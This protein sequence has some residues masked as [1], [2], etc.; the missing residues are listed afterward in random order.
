MHRD[1]LKGHRIEA[2]EFDGSLKLMY[3]W[4]VSELNQTQTNP[5]K[6]QTKEK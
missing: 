3:M 4:V 5:N 1:D 6:N 2:P